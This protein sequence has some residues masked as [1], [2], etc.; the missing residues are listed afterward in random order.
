MNILVLSDTHGNYPL[1]LKALEKAGRVDRIFHLGDGVD[2][3][4]IIE[5]ISGCT[6]FKVAGNCD[7]SAP[8]PREILVEVAGNLI[9]A[10][11]GDTYNVKA[12]LTLLHRKA[13]SVNARIVLY[14]HS[15]TGFTGHLGEILFV[16][17]GC[18]RYRWPNPGYALVT[19]EAGIA[20]A[21][22]HA[23]EP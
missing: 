11:H 13:V 22:L 2:D 12:G 8:E 17:P 7:L 15:H 19:V 20:S 9:L 14:G 1:A 16:N 3:A 23:V 6:I 4:R 5:E 21:S 10:T 18:L